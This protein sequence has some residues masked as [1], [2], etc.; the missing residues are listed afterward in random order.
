MKESTMHALSQRLINISGFVTAFILYTAAISAS[1]QDNTYVFSIDNDLQGNL[2][3]VWQD[4]NSNQSAYMIKAATKP[5][6]GSWSPTTVISTMN[7]ASVNP[8]VEVSE[9]G[10]AVA[11][12]LVNDPIS[13]NLTLVGATL[14]TGETEWSNP[15]YISNSTEEQ[16]MNFNYS[17]TID[18]NGNMV[19]LWTSL[20]N[21]ISGPSI[22]VLRTSSGILSGSWTG[23]T[24]LDTL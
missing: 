21:Q 2:V 6:G 5:A 14:P 22:P 7:I 20:L 3:T 4:N 19:A 10:N 24:T 8:I 23:P 18:D 1:S 12:W 11:I 9:N 15:F 13:S 17:I 16:V